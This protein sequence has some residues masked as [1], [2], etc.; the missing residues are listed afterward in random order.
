MG[1]Q[2]QMNITIEVLNGWKEI[3]RHLGTSVR[4][5]Q[6]YERF[7]GLPVRRPTG[8]ERGAVL[9]T[10]SE[11]GAWVS[12]NPL[13]DSFSLRPILPRNGGVAVASFRNTIA[14]QRQLR[15]EMARRNEKVRTSLELLRATSLSCR[16]NP[17]ENSNDRPH[18]R[19]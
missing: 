7:G 19:S 1:Y 16:M 17:L 2:R 14:E 18:V 8:R 5:A 4:S 6:R 10:K 15:E 12:A 11:L 9:A 3:A 13:K